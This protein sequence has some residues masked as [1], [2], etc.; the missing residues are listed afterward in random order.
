M[1]LLIVLAA[2]AASACSD[3]D[4]AQA[5][6][7]KEGYHNITLVGTA[8]GRCRDGFNGTLFVAYDEY[9]HRESGAV[10]TPGPLA[11]AYLV[12]ERRS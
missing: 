1:K 6:L 12:F 7:K 3:N 2:I 11:G 10:C 4:A 5:F 9:D 8:I